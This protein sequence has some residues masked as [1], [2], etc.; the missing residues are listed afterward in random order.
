MH[1]FVCVIFLLFFHCAKAQDVFNLGE[2]KYEGDLPVNVQPMA[3]DSLASSYLIWIEESVKAHF[4][5][6]HTEYVVILEGSGSMLLGEDTLQ[7]HEGDMVYI[8]NN[9]PHAVEVTSAKRMKVLSI[10][11]PEFKGSDRIWL[12]RSP[13]D[14]K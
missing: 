10:Q 7:V 4:H 3:S 6:A 2:I 8:P 1:Y 13:T 5:A 12:R 11:C 14:Q 9:T